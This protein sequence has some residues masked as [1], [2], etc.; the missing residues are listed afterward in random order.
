LQ[1]PKRYVSSHLEFL[2]IDEDNETS[3]SE[4]YLAFIK[5]DKRI[6]KIP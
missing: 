2:A 6:E 3:R 4:E 1:F 5:N